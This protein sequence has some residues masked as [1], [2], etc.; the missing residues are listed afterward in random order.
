MVERERGREKLGEGITCILI[1][2][3]FLGEEDEDGGIGRARPTGVLVFSEQYHYHF[4]CVL[5]F[6]S[7]TGV[8]SSFPLSSKRGCI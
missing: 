2:K 7:S 4:T 8:S 3:Y 5:F 1:K 6:S